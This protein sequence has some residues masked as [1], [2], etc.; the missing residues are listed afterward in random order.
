MKIL[1]NLVDKIAF[2]LA[3]MLGIQL[4]AFMHSYI[5]HLHGRLEEA[6]IE[7]KNFE[8][9]ANLQFGG[10]I[11]LLIQHFIKN[12]DTT[13]QATGHLIVD[14]IKRAEHYQLQINALNQESY[15]DSVIGFIQHYEQSIALETMSQFVPNIPL[16]VNS[17]ITGCV[18]ALLFS[19]ALNMFCI[20]CKS[21][22]CKF[23]R[24]KPEGSTANTH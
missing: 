21:L 9:V 20:C 8:S 3:F 23:K 1:L 7:L 11:Q 19:L 2:T 18:M 5:Q 4:P 15:I 10:D 6:K 12:T 14:L 24:T 16:N 17:L 22:Y 13:F